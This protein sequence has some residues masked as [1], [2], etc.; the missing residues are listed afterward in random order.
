MGVR[1][2]SAEKREKKGDRVFM[3]IQESVRI[4]LLSLIAGVWCGNHLDINKDQ[5]RRRRSSCYDRNELVREVQIST[6][7]ST[8]G[9]IR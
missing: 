8:G 6:R 9:F 3:Y 7:S 4:A 1:F 5:N 2:A